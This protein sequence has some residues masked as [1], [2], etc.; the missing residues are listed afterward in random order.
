MVLA[1]GLTKLHWGGAL[2]PRGSLTWGLTHCTAQTLCDQCGS[3]KVRWL[4][5]Q[6][7]VLNLWCQ[8]M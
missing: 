2:V 7:L 4:L 6:H 3:R 8:P 5:N 1:L